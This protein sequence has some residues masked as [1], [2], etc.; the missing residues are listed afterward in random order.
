M[1]GSSDEFSFRQL[2]GYKSALTKHLAR[3]NILLRVGINDSDKANEIAECLDI[4]FTKY[5]DCVEAAINYNGT[6]T[7]QRETLRQEYVE[8]FMIVTDI[9]AQLTALPLDQ[10]EIG[11]E[12]GS[13]APE[14]EVFPPQ[15]PCSSLNANAKAFV[16]VRP[17]EITLF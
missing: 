9:C 8:K 1:A 15:M 7:A 17:R 12:T 6:G 4:C 13:H 5:S 11:S 16:S 14:G 3:A 10:A 2:G